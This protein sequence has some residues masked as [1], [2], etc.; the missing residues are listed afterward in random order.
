MGQQGALGGVLFFIPIVNLAVFGYMLKVAQ[1]VAQGNPRPLP[2]WGEFGEHF[3]RG[4]HWLAIQI[5]YQLPTIILYALFF[6]VIV[7]A[8]GAADSQ[9]GAMARGRLARWACACC[10]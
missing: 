6:C 5:V 9:R 7:A 8:G 10:R 2:E 4:L 3:I 1:N